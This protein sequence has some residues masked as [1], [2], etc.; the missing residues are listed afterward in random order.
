MEK[1]TFWRCLSYWIWRCS[2]LLC[3]CARGP[4]IGQIEVTWPLEIESTWFSMFWE[5]CFHTLY[6]MLWC[7]IVLYCSLFTQFARRISSQW[8]YCSGSTV[9]GGTCAPKVVCCHH[10]SRCKVASP[11]HQWKWH[12]FTRL[13][14]PQMFSWAWVQS[15]FFS[16]MTSR[17]HWRRRREIR[18]HGWR[19]LDWSLAAFRCQCGEGL[20]VVS[21]ECV[22]ILFVS[23]PPPNCF[24]SRRHGWRS[25]WFDSR[26][27]THRSKTS[28]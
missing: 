18:R 8:F 20:H 12:V 13:E 14:T 15:L 11:G 10:A 2:I 4:R 9:A 16:G 26:D 25:C 5:N 7:L 3:Q 22:S 23:V 17:R 19:R 6:C 21:I 27:N 1:E 24:W 28:S